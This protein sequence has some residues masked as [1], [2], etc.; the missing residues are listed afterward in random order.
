MAEQLQ[1][2][3]RMDD[4]GYDNE[5]EKKMH[6]T[7]AVFFGVIIIIFIGFKAHENSQS[8]SEDVA[9]EPTATV[10]ITEQPV[11]ESNIP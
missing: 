9:V 2:I 8:T 3:E 5:S 11:T 10:E 4:M 1:K 7:M 6:R